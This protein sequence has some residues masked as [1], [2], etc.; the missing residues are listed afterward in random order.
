MDWSKAKTI[1][2]VALLFANA[3]LGYFVI[4]DSL[5]SNASGKAAADIQVEELL[6]RRDITLQSE[7]PVTPESLMSITV[8]FERN[9]PYDINS[10]YFDG[11]GIRELKGEEIEEVYRGYE[12]VTIKNGKLLIYENRDRMAVV[13]K[14]VELEAAENTAKEFLQERGYSSADMKLTY[15]QEEKGGYRLE[16]SKILENSYVE[17]GNTSFLIAGD[18]VKR[19]ERTWLNT[20]EIQQSDL[21]L[22]PAEKAILELLSI[23][24]AHGK[25]VTD[26]SL[27]Y[28]F[29]PEKQNNYDGYQQ[30]TQGNAVPGWRIQFEDG[31]K[32]VLDSE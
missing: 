13:T 17:V 6:Q 10:R 7:I 20:V 8:E 15:H 21:S 27:C 11:K 25:T 3:I 26:I 29:D 14:A 4:T 31:T 23:E 5:E 32:L 1:L 9:E 24:Q 2:I 22:I 19:M 28:Y 12:S 30:A 18:T 16:Y